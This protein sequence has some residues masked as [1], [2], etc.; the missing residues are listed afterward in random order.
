MEKK[1]MEKYRLSNKDLEKKIEK[2]KLRA[3]LSV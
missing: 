3:R 1:G 2:E